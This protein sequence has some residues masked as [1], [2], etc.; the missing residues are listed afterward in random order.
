MNN[1]NILKYG[2]TKNIFSNIKQFFRN[3]KYAYQRATKGYCDADIWN[4][5]DHYLQYL[6]V[7][8]QA[9]AEIAHGYPSH[10]FP[11]MQDWRNYIKE[12]AQHFYNA[13]EESETENKK[14]VDRLYDNI[15]KYRQEN[16]IPT[17][18]ISL[19]GK[20]RTDEEKQLV[21]EWL[22]ADSEYFKFREHEM[23]TAFNMMRSVFFHL[24]D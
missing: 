7:T 1:L 18:Q 22:E 24:W 17:N 12:I 6:D 21:D 3:L 9:L 8:L 4:L 13:R 19:L 20:Y 14:T 15:L 16:N 2:Y 10:M 11:T 5:D 23:H